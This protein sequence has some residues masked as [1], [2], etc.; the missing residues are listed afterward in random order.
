MRRWNYGSKLPMWD[1]YDGL[2]ETPEL[3]LAD[4]AFIFDWRK[5]EGWPLL[6]ETAELCVSV[7]VPA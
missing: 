4:I 5:E 3:I 2:E 1:G 7:P 6:V